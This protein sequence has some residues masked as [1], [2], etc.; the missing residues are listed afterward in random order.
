MKIILLG[1]SNP[2]TKRV[3]NAVIRAQCN[4]EVLGFLDNDSSKKGE[5][6]FEY[7]ILGGFEVLDKYIKDDI[8]F[9][10]L[11][12]GSTKLRYETSKYMSE[13]GC[14]FTN[15]IYPSVDLCMVK[16]GLGNYIQESVIVQAGCHIGNNSSIHMAS[17]IGH[18]SNIGNSVFIAHGVSISG[19][20][21]I[22]DGTFVG[23]HAT[24]LPRLKIGKWVTIG[25]GAVVTKDVPDYA[26]VVGNPAKVVKYNDN[27]Y[28]SGN[29]F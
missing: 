11:I 6:F 7:E 18:E 14:K 29:I 9:V 1:A 8:Y 12:T 26:V 20:V 22:G 2:E 13:K 23:T 15:L 25:A 5:K 3:I 28:S 10:N 16:V 17:I 21:T 4:L 19:F 27:V 24:I